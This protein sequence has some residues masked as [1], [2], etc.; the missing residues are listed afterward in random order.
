MVKGKPRT[1]SRASSSRSKSSRGRR[2]GSAVQVPRSALLV[3]EDELEDLA[4]LLDLLPELRMTARVMRD[5]LTPPRGSARGSADR[6]G[7]FAGELFNQRLEGHLTAAAKSYMQR[8]DT[9][10]PADL[11]EAVEGIRGA[12][13]CRLYRLAAAIRLLQADR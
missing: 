3:L 10:T 1:G 11:N 9:M 8:A 5:I 12:V 4:A 7:E 6:V 2:T 13:Q